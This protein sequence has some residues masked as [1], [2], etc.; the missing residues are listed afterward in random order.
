[1]GATIDLLGLGRVEVD[2]EHGP[3]RIPLVTDAGIRWADA[4]TLRVILARLERVA[5]IG[6]G[7][8]S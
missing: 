3:P 1:M 2:V 5:A 7:E 6:H 4:S 8:A